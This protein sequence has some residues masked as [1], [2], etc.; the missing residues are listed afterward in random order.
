MIPP[1]DFMEIEV[2][3][4]TVKTEIMDDELFGTNTETW[5]TCGVKNGDGVLDMKVEKIKLESDVKTE[6]FEASEV[7]DESGCHRFANRVKTEHNNHAAADQIK[8]EHDTAIK[9]LESAQMTE[10]LIIKDENDCEN[11]NTSSIK[12][13]LFCTECNDIFTSDE[14]LNVHFDEAH[15]RIH[16][17]SR[18]EYTT[19]HKSN[20]A[21]HM[22]THSKA[23]GSYN[24][25]ICIHCN[26]RLSNKVSLDN[27]I[28]MKH[29]DFIASVS[30][31]VYD[32]D[33][34]AYK[35]TH[36]SDLARHILKHNKAGITCIH[37]YARFSTKINLDN[38]I[39]K[40]HPDMLKQ[41]KSK[42]NK[43]YTC[44]HCNV[45]SFT[46]KRYLDE[47]SIK[48][49]P[50][51][52]ASVSS[53]IH[54]CPH[55]T[56]K[57]TLKFQ[58]DRHVLNH[59]ETK[60]NIELCACIHCEATFKYRRNLDDHVIRKHP[61]FAASVFRKIHECTY[62]S[63][64][65]TIKS[66][67]V[68]HLLK[69]PEAEGI[70]DFR[71]CTHCN[72]KFSNQA[73]LDNHIVKNHPDFIT[74]VSS[75]VHECSH[76]TYKSANKYYFA[77]HVLTHSLTNGRFTCIHCNATFRSKMTLDDHTIRMH[78]TF[79]S[80]VTTK[81]YGCT[82]CAYKTTSRTNFHRH[83]SRHT[84]AESKN[85]T[86]CIHCNASFLRKL[87]DIH[88]IKEHPEFA[89][90]V[91]RKSYECAHCAYKTFKRHMLVKHLSIHANRHKVSIC[92]HCH[93]RFASKTALEDH[94]VREHPDFC[95]PDSSKT[96][97]STHKSNANTE[98]KHNKLNTCIHCNV[99]F[100]SKRNLDNHTIKKHPDFITSV[101]S[102]M[103]DC[104]HCAYKS[105][106]KIQLDRHLSN[107]SEAKCDLDRCT[108]IH[109]KASFKC[110]RNLDD[111]IIRMHPDFIAS[112]CRKIH[113]CAYCTYKTTIKANLIRHRLKHPE[114]KGS[115]YF[116][117]HCNAT[118]T[119]KRN[120][121]DHIVK[122]HPDF[123]TAVSNK[124]HECSYCTYKTTSKRSFD[125]HSFTHSFTHSLPT[126]I[127]CKATFRNRITLDDH[128]IRIHPSFISSVTRKI[129]RCT[130]CAY[131]TTWKS[132]F[133]R[134]MRRHNEVE[135]SDDLTTCTHCK[136]SFPNKLIGFHIIKEHP[137]IAKVSK[138]LFKCAHC[139]Y[140]TFRR[141]VLVKHLSKHHA[142][143][144]SCKLSNCMHCNAT[145][146]YKR[147]LDT[148]IVKEHP[149]FIS[150]G[151]GQR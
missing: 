1:E 133:Y 86:T 46:S 24:P 126:C 64:K 9:K 99:T 94:I 35:T 78:P 128:I 83:M 127:H 151:S 79:T 13:L 25:S 75:K 55:C 40:E 132:N 33:H 135:D 142:T 130:C 76:C 131:K 51:L 105:T 81:I 147:N 110:K 148:H 89:E 10:E 118:Y 144:K 143:T 125:E 112:V 50:N 45:A 117:I 121:D 17:C 91:D 136:A 7:I 3:E 65:T 54:D 15:Q 139:K 26:A 57:T 80:S 8:M 70:V 87:I 6:Q 122:K 11:Q 67:L 58:L 93:V 73:N 18:C 47:H 115:H 88:I 113:E 116:C 22:V 14:D 71:I 2:G 129:Y 95:S 23:D 19:T 30:S 74:S 146:R 16:K 72:A 60:C 114:E 44:V 59:P 21:E 90:T 149:D 85:L 36:K 106:W 119:S 92:I 109:C 31:K 102:K 84:G 138:N 5:M 111:H 4:V 62:C 34:C 108:C 39:V 145:F 53:K 98:S 32:C 37:C 69:H 56:Y 20:L 101:T 43:P 120:L 48:E 38:H 77:N 107:H 63:F 12:Q 137:E 82:H 97:Q 141:Y 28:I 66:H 27:H 150:S 68:S 103:Y 49:H 42:H 61:D 124:V 100:A 104:P 134:H 29:P 41:T 52:F 123:I 140:K 96:H